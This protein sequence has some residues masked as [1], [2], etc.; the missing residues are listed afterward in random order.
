MSTDFRTYAIP[1][2]L[3]PVFFERKLMA[4]EEEKEVSVG[5]YDKSATRVVSKPVG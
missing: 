1:W 2:N 3:F 5:S 4:L